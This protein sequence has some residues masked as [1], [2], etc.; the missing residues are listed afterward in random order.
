MNGY[1]L[2]LQERRENERTAPEPKRQRTASAFQLLSEIVASGG[3][4]DSDD[5]GALCSFLI[6]IPPL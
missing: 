4:C 2:P 3:G 6:R 1:T 5:Y